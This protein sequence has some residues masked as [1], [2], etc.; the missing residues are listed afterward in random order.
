MIRHAN[1]STVGMNFNVSTNTGIG[2]YFGIL[3]GAFIFS[4]LSTVQFYV[5]CTISSTKLHSQMLNA[6]LRSPMSFFDQN[7]VGK[8]YS[9]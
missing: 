9:S 6:V 1:E 4:F 8:T 2:I 3:G 7:P 5:I